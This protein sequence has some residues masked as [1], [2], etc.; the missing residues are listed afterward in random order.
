MSVGR[1]SRFLRIFVAIAIVALARVTWAHPTV[2]NVLDVDI[3]TDH[4]TVMARVSMEEVLL[5][6]AVGGAG[7][8]DEMRT[9][10]ALAHGAYV[11]RHLH[12]RAD[13]R[14]IEGKL[15]QTTAP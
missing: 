2:E 7:I 1:G 10:A 9:Q 14:P 6:E 12:L 3:W 15:G 4:V 13:G 11:L 5:A 8:S